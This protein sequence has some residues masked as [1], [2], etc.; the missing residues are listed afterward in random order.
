MVTGVP[1]SG[2][3][4]LGTALAD[5]LRVPFLSRDQVRGGLMATAG[6]WTGELR[7]PPPR[8]T[9]VDTFAELVEAAARLNVT[10]VLEFVVTPER[11]DA[12]RRISDAASCLVIVTHSD[13][14]AARAERRDREDRLLNRP[15]VLAALGHRT[16]ND[17]I[18]DPERARIASEIQTDFDVPV[19]T[20][21]TDARYEPP[22]ESIVEWI[23]RRSR[24]RCEER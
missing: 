22:L 13:G 18:A 4:W 15:D 11:R 24:A 2:K 1:G 17:Y 20:V 8:E 14:A 12:F 19:L 10:F 5:A 9:A 16:I 23:V 21:N 7:D 6:L 3:T